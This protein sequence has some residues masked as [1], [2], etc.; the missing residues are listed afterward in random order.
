MLFVPNI[1]WAKF[2]QPAD[3]EKYAKRENKVLL[4]L[5]RFGEIAI[6]IIL[7]VFTSINP[8]LKIYPE[9][10]YFDWRMIMWVMAFVLMI[11]YEFYWIKY[12]RSRKTM[13]DMYSSFAGFPVAGAT[14][15][16]V[17]TFLLGLYSLNIILIVCSVILGIGHIGIH[18]LHKKEAIG[19]LS[20]S[21]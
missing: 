20:D 8:Y 15:P 13:K 1:F 10:I 21:D 14:L 2:G 12:F 19:I 4:A 9:G 17:A 18:I 7:L 5:E 11:L 3:Y 16:V 6:S